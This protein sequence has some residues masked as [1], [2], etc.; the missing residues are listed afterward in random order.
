MRL[1]SKH[2]QVPR[3]TRRSYCLAIRLATLATLAVSTGCR[4][5]AVADEETLGSAVAAV[6]V[7]VDTSS[8]ADVID[9]GGLVR[10]R[11]GAEASLAA[12]APTRIE[13]ILVVVGDRVA[14][15][16]A[17]VEFEPVLFEAALSSAESSLL[18]AEQGQTRAQRLVAAGVAPRRDLEQANAALASARAA[19]LAARRARQLTTLRA[20]FAGV[21]TRVS[22]VRGANVNEQQPLVEIADPARVDVVL[23]LAPDVSHRVRAGQAVALRASAASG[24]PSIGDGQ[25]ADISAVVDSGS[26]SV[27][28]RVT[29]TRMSVPLR[30]GETLFGSI[31]AETHHSAIVIPDQALVP[32]EEGFRVFVVDTARVAHARRVTVGG[33]SPQGVWI[34]E[35]I[36][37]GET[38]VTAGAYGLDDGSVVLF[39]QKKP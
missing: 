27:A 33:R 23:Q 15:G 36:R 29:V 31:T 17:L 30:I 25:V 35:G 34:R 11:M 13:R 9:A 14:A 22:A 1:S 3:P 21:V 12:P 19:A 26:R 8:F 6:T 18:A 7:R 20:P 24:T 10:S 4:R 28:V 37:R 32:H 38:I 2:K 16:E 5:D 39:D